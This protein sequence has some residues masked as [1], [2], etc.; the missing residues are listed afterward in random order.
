MIGYANNLNYN[1]TIHTL[2]AFHFQ[3]TVN[4]LLIEG[5]N[6]SCWYDKLMFLVPQNHLSSLWHINK[7]LCGRWR[8]TFE[9]PQTNLMRINFYTDFWVNKTGFDLQISNICGG[10]LYGTS[11]ILTT[12]DVINSYRCEWI[13]IVREGRTIQIT[14]DDFNLQDNE[15]CQSSYFMIRNGGSSNSPYLGN[16]RY[17]GTNRPSIPESASNRVNVLF[18]AAFGRHVVRLHNH[19]ISKL[20]WGQLITNLI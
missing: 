6:R 1:W 16:G 11:G 12:D 18:Y 9:L 15:N 8:G 3:V 13:I 19:R 4:D 10:T 7:T 20:H 14:F 5:D 2:Q 17:C